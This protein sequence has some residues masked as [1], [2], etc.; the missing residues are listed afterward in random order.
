ML[1]GLRLVRPGESTQPVRRTSVGILHV[2][3]GSGATVVGDRRF[4]WDTGDAIVVPNWTWHH[5]ES[6]SSDDAILFSM[7]DQPLLEPLGLYR[8]ERR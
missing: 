7:S 8:E 5:H 1:C 3:R 2:V 6:R 4:E